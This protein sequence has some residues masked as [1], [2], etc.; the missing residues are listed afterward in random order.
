MLVWGLCTCVCLLDNEWKLLR[1][2][3]AG[4][5]IEGIRCQWPHG[6]IVP[7]GGGRLSF[8]CVCARLRFMA[9]L[10]HRERQQLELRLSIKKEREFG[11]L[12]SCL[13]LQFPLQCC[14]SQVLC[15]SRG[16]THLRG[17][18]GPKD[19]VPNVLRSFLIHSFHLFT[20]KKIARSQT[21]KGNVKFDRHREGH[22]SF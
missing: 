1:P 12:L 19:D 13:D 16:R 10:C 20:Y 3:T 8:T 5:R 9:A 2:S 22:F 7:A 21:C 11:G 15:V 6:P 17:T 14:T 4:R 18:R